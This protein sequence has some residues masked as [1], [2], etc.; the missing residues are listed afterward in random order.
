MLTTTSRINELELGTTLEGRCRCSSPMWLDVGGKSS[1]GKKGLLGAFSFPVLVRSYTPLQAHEQ[2]STGMGRSVGYVIGWR[3]VLGMVISH[4]R[5]T[6]VPVEP[7]LSLGF[8][9]A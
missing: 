5:C 3:M 9:A 8:P 6:F 4:V 1:G 7:E 2:R